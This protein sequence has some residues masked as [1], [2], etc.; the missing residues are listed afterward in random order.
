VQYAKVPT[1][2]GHVFR[3]EGVRGPVWYAKYRLPDGRQRQRRIGPAWTKVGRPATGTY[4]RRTAR[5][6][7]ADLLD[8]ERERYVPGSRLPELTFAEAAREWLRYVEHDRACKPSTLGGYRSSVNGL[9]IP[10]FGDRL[11]AEVTPADIERWRATL[12]TAA[13][14][15]NKLLVELHGI[16]RRAQRLYGLRENPAARV[17]P[18]RAPRRL[19]LQV[20]SPEEVRALVRAADSEQDAAIY[21]TAALTGL[22]RGELLALRW[23]DVDFRRARCACR[24][25]SPPGR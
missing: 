2:S 4:T 16:F 25:R 22:H 17:E 23:R 12:T 18:L 13:R 3:R 19:D 24:A 20:Y 1:F 21:L 15:R 6:A 9:L 5:A 8:L 10:A 14:T 7:L 11:V